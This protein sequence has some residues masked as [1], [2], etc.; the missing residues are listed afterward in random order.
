MLD[1]PIEYSRNVKQMHVLISKRKKLFE[2][3]TMFNF[4]NSNKLE[5][6]LPIP[7]TK[8]S[9][10]LCKCLRQCLLQSHRQKY[11]IIMDKE[12]GNL[13]R[14]DMLTQDGFVKYTIT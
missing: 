4:L 1:V 11:I 8:T 5:D 3:Q 14:N 7:W 12:H 10:E 13:L 2:F 9:K 6:F